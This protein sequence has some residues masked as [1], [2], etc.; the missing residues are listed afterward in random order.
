MANVILIGTGTPNPDPLR[1]GP[2][3]A[4][5]HNSKLYLVDFGVGLIRQINKLDIDISQIDTAFLTHLHSDHTLG[6]SDLILTPW[7]LGRKE[8]LKLYG[9]KGLGD[10]SQHTLKAYELDINERIN[11]L[12]KAN[13][14]G[15]QVKVTHIDEGLIYDDDIK[16]EAIRVPHGNFESYAFKFTTDNVIVVSGDTAPS[17][18]LTE[19]AMNCD[20]L[21][22]E[23]YYTEGLKT[24]SSQWQQYHAAVHTSAVALGKIA[25]LV[26]PKK[27]VL[28]H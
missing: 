27:L 10:M 22:H 18:K 19:F 9:P 23:V 6:L 8:P 5:E 28:Y 26:Q 7:I 25:N 17:D 15:Y 4:I 13:T 16:V 14:T 12:E 2:C 11:G 24:R 21:V 1:S 20:I 3:V